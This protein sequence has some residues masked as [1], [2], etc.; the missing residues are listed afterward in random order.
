MNSRKKALVIG[1]GS[2]G[3][4]HI[5]NLI[6]LEFDVFVFDIN[7]NNYEMLSQN[8]KNIKLFYSLNE[9]IFNLKIESCHLL[10]ISTW[11]PSHFRFFQLGVNLNIKK[12]IFEKPICCS[13]F[14][15]DQ[16]YKISKKNKI[17]FIVHFKRDF[18]GLEGSIK[19]ILKQYGQKPTMIN[20]HGGAACLVTNGIHFINIACNIFNEYPIAVFSDMKNS[21][22]NPRNKNLGYYEGSIKLYF[23]NKKFFCIS[24]TNHSSINNSLNIYTEMLRVDVEGKKI[25]LGKNSNFIK[26]K[27][28]KHS[29][30]TRKLI[31]EINENNYYK[32]CIRE[33]HSTKNK[34]EHYLKIN[35]I[36]LESLRSSQKKKILQFKKLNK[37]D[38]LKKWHI[39]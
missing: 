24:N 30:V 26:T 39:S 5:M 14:Q 10:V 15:Q 6:D 32:N 11:G 16:I 7:F 8:H 4:K 31:K 22:I 21:G 38:Y 29:L 37:K 18:N 9:L 2:I 35:N 20:V 12:I 27:L 3:V 25:F 13:N 28:T 23:R 34:H 33:L 19:N 1:S 17:K 36:I